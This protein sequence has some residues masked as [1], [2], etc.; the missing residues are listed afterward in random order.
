MYIFV[1]FSFSKDVE[2]PSKIEH[3]ERRIPS[4]TV[5]EVA[6]IQPKYEDE[7]SERIVEIPTIR[8]IDKEV[9]TPVYHDVIVT[10]HPRKIVDV[11]R[12]VTKN[13]PI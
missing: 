4:R 2:V 5:K 10:V 6:K 1:I 11:H 8:Y 9:D 13:V 7:Y 12:E 3:R